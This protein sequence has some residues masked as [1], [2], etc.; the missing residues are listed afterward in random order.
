[1]TAESRPRALHVLVADDESIIV[2]AVGRML[3]RAGHVAHGAA[4]A[5]EALG[6]I[7]RQPLDA[8][9]VDLHMPGGG[10][11]VLEA[12]TALPSFRGPSVLLT[13]DD[14]TD[15]GLPT[16]PGLIRMQ[17]PFRYDELLRVVE[18]G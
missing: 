7:A 12:L 11:A 8:A 1:M 6:V 10:A 5:H 14:P 3:E 2:R 13:G 15:P 16:L 18:G 9:I 17:K 4:D